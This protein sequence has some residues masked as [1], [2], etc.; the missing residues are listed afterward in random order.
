MMIGLPSVVNSKMYWGIGLL[1]WIRG[2]ELYSFCSA[3]GPPDL[4]MML[5]YSV[6]DQGGSF[7]DIPKGIK[8]FSVT[9]Y[10][11]KMIVHGKN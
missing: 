2:K 11:V 4:I 9:K 6:R 1:Y 7:M 3:L 10:V 5:L 8:D